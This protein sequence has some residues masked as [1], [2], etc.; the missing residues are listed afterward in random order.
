M[1]GFFA[2][3]IDNTGFGNILEIVVCPSVSPVHARRQPP[4][5]RQMAHRKGATPKSGS[6]PSYLSTQPILQ[7][8]QRGP[9]APYPLKENISGALIRVVVFISGAFAPG[10]GRIARALRKGNRAGCFARRIQ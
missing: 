9:L 2:L 6:P 4:W 10:H 3:A 7:S 5:I 1:D 8:K